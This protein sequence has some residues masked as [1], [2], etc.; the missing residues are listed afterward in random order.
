MTSA[1]VFVSYS[2]PDRACAFEIVEH[3]E[4]RNINV[5]IAPRDISPSVDWAAEIIDAIA[6]T[7]LMVLVFSAHCNGSQQVRREVERAVH[8]NL[9][10]LPFRIEDVLP[11]KS[12]EYFL[13]TQHWMNAF[14]SPGEAHYQQLA[15]HIERLLNADRQPSPDVAATPRPVVA[16][17]VAVPAGVDLDSLERGLAF[18]LGPIAKLIIQRALHSGAGAQNLIAA[19]AG[20][21]ES[22]AARSA[23]IQQFSPDR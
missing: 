17:P 14:P 12:L 8:R 4:A 19:C 2:N 13:S 18:H 20:E 9:P 6:K 15:I 7:R 5:W 10:V 22:D 1:D 11:A 21:I 16:T 3:L 23:F